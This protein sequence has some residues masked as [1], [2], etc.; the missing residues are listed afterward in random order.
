MDD[1][2]EVAKDVY[3]NPRVIGAVGPFSEGDLEGFVA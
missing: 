3:G 2:H 1:V